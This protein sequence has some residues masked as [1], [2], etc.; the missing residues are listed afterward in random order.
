MITILRSLPFV[1]GVLYAGF[2][3][4]EC[5]PL[6]N[7]HKVFQNQEVYKDMLIIKLKRV[8]EALELQDVNITMKTA[9]GNEKIYSVKVP[10]W[11]ASSDKLKYAI[12]DNLQ[13]LSVQA[14]YKDDCSETAYVQQFKD[15][16]VSSK[17][18]H[19][20]IRWVG[21][22]FYYLITGCFGPFDQ[23]KSSR[24]IE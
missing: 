19:V 21:E 9:D 10:Y 2:A 18:K 11:V 16:I 23:H 15:I 1:L 3:Q 17:L 6:V 20:M 14:S 13:S 8:N 12:P 22:D 7:T 24:E 4:A 5:T